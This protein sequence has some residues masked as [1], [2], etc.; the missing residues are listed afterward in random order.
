MFVLAVL[1]FVCFLVFDRKGNLSVS[2]GVCL[3][4]LAVAAGVMYAGIHSEMADTEIWNG[5]ITSKTRDKVGCRHSYTCNC[6]N[7]C[8][9]KGSCDQVC[10]TCYE[11]DYDVDWNL[12]STIG[13]FRIDGVSR[14]GLKEPSRW[15]VAQVGDPVSDTHHF[16]NYIKGA[17]ENVFNRQGTKISYPI[18]AYPSAIYDYYKINRAIDTNGLVLNINQWNSE[19]SLALRT[20]GPTKQVNLVI[21]FTPN[22]EDFA[23]QLE[24]AWLG[25]KKNDVIVVIGNTRNEIKWVKVISWTKNEDFKVAL[26]DNLRQMTL[27]DPR[28]VVTAIA[29]TINKSF[30]RRSMKEF[31]YL[32]YHVEP[33]VGF[34]VAAFLLFFSI[35]GGYIFIRR[36]S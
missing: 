5:Q 21:V 32:E 27:E 15:T 8:D 29:T 30:V 25:G 1:A 22:P 9:S 34:V 18:P 2:A 16:T 31:E 28:V 20:L 36:N 26:R 35:L 13:T 12:R 11:H 10:Q 23:D 33:P 17:R 24:A 7:V 19:I 3:L 14:Q 6:V 4:A